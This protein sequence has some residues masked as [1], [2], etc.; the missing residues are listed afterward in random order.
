MNLPANERWIIDVLEY[1]S[2]QRNVETPI[3]ER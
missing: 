1:L 3:L 2:A